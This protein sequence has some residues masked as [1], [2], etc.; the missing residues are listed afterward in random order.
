MRCFVFE[1]DE[2]NPERTGGREVRYF[3]RCFQVKM[4][5]E[6]RCNNISSRHH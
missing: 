4:E 2:D 3:E 6:V 5:R 1:N